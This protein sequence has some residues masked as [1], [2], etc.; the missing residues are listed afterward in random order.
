[1][2]NDHLQN[3]TS[4]YDPY[5]SWPEY[6]IAGLLDQYGLPFIYEKPTAVLDQGKVRLWY[7]DFTLSY[8]PVIEYFGVNGDEGYR[9]RTAYKLS[10]YAQNQIEVLPVY[11]RDMSG[12]WQGRLLG[13]IDH[14]LEGR[15]T[16]YRTAVRD[17]Y[18]SRPSRR[19]SYRLH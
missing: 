14:A 18:S 1:M 16:R 2:L 6:Q 9:R 11:P 15:L 17:N 8:G 4:R 10:T 13:R 7:P 12:K 5:K 3:P 19:S